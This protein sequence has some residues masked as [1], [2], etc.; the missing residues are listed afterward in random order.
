MRILSNCSEKY[1]T[2]RNIFYSLSVTSSL[3]AK[4]PGYSSCSFTQLSTGHAHFSNDRIRISCEPDR[5]TLVFFSCKTAV[6]TTRNAWFDVCGELLHPVFNPEKKPTFEQKLT[7]T[8]ALFSLYFLD[9][10]CFHQLMVCSRGHGKTN[11]YA[12]IQKKKY[13]YIHTHFSKNNFKKPGTRPQRAYS[14]L[15]E[16]IWFKDLNAL[17]VMDK[18][19]DLS[20]FFSMQLRE[21]TQANL[22][23]S[24]SLNF[25]I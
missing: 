25:C 1:F 9:M 6:N 5:P 3:P 19:T 20:K 10:G 22:P 24:L 8:Q 21:T 4:P 15:W 14:R 16:C 11:K 23:E 12:N 2:H 18:Y 17:L 13:A 7:F